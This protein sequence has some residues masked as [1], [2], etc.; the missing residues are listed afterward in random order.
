MGR[1]VLKPTWSRLIA[2]SHMIMYARVVILTVLASSAIA[3][4]SSSSPPSA[5]SLAAKIPG[6]HPAAAFQ[7]S[8]YSQQEVTCQFSSAGINYASIDMATFR[9]QSDERSWMT[10]MNGQ[11]YGCCVQGNGWAVDVKASL[12]APQDSY[13]LGKVAPILGGK[14]VTAP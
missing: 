1:D 12:S 11:G 2:S 10:Y 8:M 4:C 9:S 6:C 14:V 3:A 5:S 7:P 13:P